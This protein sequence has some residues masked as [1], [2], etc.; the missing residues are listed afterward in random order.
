MRRLWQTAL[1]FSVA[2]MPYGISHGQ[3]VLE[4]EIPRSALSPATPGESITA[5]QPSGITVDDVRSAAN[6]YID[7]K[8]AEDGT[9]YIFDDMTEEDLGLSRGAIRADRFGRIDSNTWVIGAGFWGEDGTPYD[10]DLV[11]TGTS[12]DN[13]TFKEMSIFMAG[14][15]QRYMWEEEGGFV[16]R[17]PLGTLEPSEPRTMEGLPRAGVF[18]SEPIVV[19]PGDFEQR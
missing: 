15:S 2:L 5:P 3:E 17:K 7:D 9:F 13:L 10:V 6:Q 4:G 19:S 12:P 1:V 18:D 8:I 11:F 16:V 14:D